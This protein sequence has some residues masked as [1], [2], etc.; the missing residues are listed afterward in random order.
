M[1]LAWRKFGRQSSADR[2]LLPTPSTGHDHIELVGCQAGYPG[3]FCQRAAGRKWRGRTCRQ[4]D[5]A[6]ATGQRSRTRRRPASDSSGRRRSH[7]PRRGAAFAWFLDRAT[8]PA[9]Q[10]DRW[11]AAERRTRRR[12]ILTRVAGTVSA[13][14]VLSSTLFAGLESGTATLPP[15]ETLPTPTGP[16]D[17]V[18]AARLSKQADALN[19]GDPLTELQLRVAAHTLDPGNAAYRSTLSQLL[20]GPRPLNM[21]TATLGP[22]TA[23]AFASSTRV[24]VAGQAGVQE[25]TGGRAVD[26]RQR[27]GASRGPRRDGGRLRQRRPVG[28]KRPRWRSR[29]VC[30]F[31]R[32]RAGG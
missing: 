28:F 14:L 31:T 13:L 12:P 3:S 23:M 17:P 18:L 22:I 7:E 24:A 15:R 11:S 20:L 26:D 1:V 29:P 9:E 8:G 32:C 25:L 16:G 19:R 5:K 30:R 21:V 2:A 6:R 27:G 4:Q 10:T